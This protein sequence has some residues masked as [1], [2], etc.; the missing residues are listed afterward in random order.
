VP[1][2]LLPRPSR[3]LYSSA[4]M[5]S[6]RR[7]GRRIAE[8]LLAAAKRCCGAG[9]YGTALFADRYKLQ[10]MALARSGARRPF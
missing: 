7:T 9:Q 2:R 10:Y 4:A 5:R 8:T 6:I 3:L 1:P